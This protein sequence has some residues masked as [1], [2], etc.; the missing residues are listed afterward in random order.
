M[1]PRLLMMLIFIH[2][3]AAPTNPHTA[4]LYIVECMASG[5]RDFSLLC[6]HYTQFI[7]SNK[8]ST[9]SSV[10]FGFAEVHK[11]CEL[12]GVYSDSHNLRDYRGELGSCDGRLAKL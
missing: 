10:R 9:L 1:I 11:T 8:I 12:L 5:A 6:L 3:D 2:V 4:P 7:Q